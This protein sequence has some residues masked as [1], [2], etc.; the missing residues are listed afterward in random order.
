MHITFASTKLAKEANDSRL[1]KRAHGPE[2]AKKIRLR[3]DAA[4]AARCLEDLRN[5]P[6]RW[7]ELGENRDEQISVDLDGPYRL[8]FIPSGNSVARK[9]DGGL[10]WSLITALEV[11]EITNTHGK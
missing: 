2:R 5:A 10:D 11:V 8:I 6:G 4:A 7:H 1:L 9:P 3:L